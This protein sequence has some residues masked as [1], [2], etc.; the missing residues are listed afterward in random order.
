MDGLLKDIRYALRTLLKRPGF[1]LV[2]VITLGL[3]I[4]AN[5]A[6]FTL[7]NAVIYKKLPVAN[8]NELVLF[9]DSAGEGTRNSDGDPSP[10]RADLFSYS[11]YE[12]FRDHDQS[13]QGLSAFRSGESRLSVR[14]PE[15]QS[16]ESAQRASG[17]LVSGN[18]FSVLGVNALLGR[19]LTPED[20]KA[21][22]HPAAVMSYNHWKQEWNGDPQIVN[23]E[24][25]LNG[26]SFTVVGVAPPEF[27]GVRVRR[28]PDFWLPLAFQPQIELRKSY[29]DDKQIYWLNFVGRLKPSV[30]IEQAQAAANLSLQQ[31]VTAEV[32]SKLNDDIRKAIAGMFVKLGSGARGIS[33]LRLFYSESLKMLMVIVALVLLIAC[34]NVGNL[35]LSR[36]ASRQGEISL[37]LAL[38][39]NRIRIIRQLLTESLLLA[40]LGGIVGIFLAQWGVSL[41]VTLV[42]KTS[43]IDVRPDFVVL[44]FTAGVALVSGLIFGMVPALR[45]SKMDLTSALKEK[46]EGTKR[47]GRV[48]L[49]SA[50]VV[51]Q[52]ALSMVLLAGA[53]LFA[54][55]LMKLQREEVGFNR[56][57]LLLAQVDPRLAGYKPAELGTLYRNLADR[58]NSVPGVQRATL[59][60]Y[61]PMSGT[62]TSSN[63][64][65]VG[66]EAKDNEDLVV[67]DMLIGPGYGESLGA[68][69]LLGRE[70]DQRDTESGAKVAVVNQ[71]FADYFFHGQNPIG[72]QFHFGDED[73]DAKE[74][75]ELI[76]I[77]GVLGNVKYDSAREKAERMVL[78]PIAQAVG[79]TTFNANWQIRTNGDPASLAPA[80]RQAISQVDARLP[81]YSVGTMEEQVQ[82][83]LRQE[84]LIA[85]LVSFFGLLALLLASIGLYGLMAHGVVRRTREIGI[86]MALGAERSMIIWMVLRE[87]MVLV[88]L[89]IAI[90]VP[91]AIGASRLIASQLFG[92]NPS[93]PVTLALSGVLLTG[94]ALLAGF[95]PARKASKVDPL[96][97]LRYE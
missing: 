4:G 53:G 3:G 97:A 23:R 94:V 70:I 16:G 20:D 26:T 77:V 74:K 62:S 63:V 96:I 22:A 72:R 36:A 10:G 18:Y 79:P 88:L 45:A 9:S 33:G 58:L 82:G 66:Y 93:D 55:S 32:G 5:T 75:P 42:A 48:G 49:A 68:Q 15:L 40:L 50:L 24:V 69:L 19:V 90:G 78:R 73:E 43:P 91:A 89:G 41:L 27:F 35:L 52:V 6:I 51:S 86:R 57:N 95:L 76:E 2:A 39:A 13:Y 21:A 60:S 31:F 12:Y 84:K 67:Q 61:T 56:D 34:A 87:T 44:G 81:V 30:T 7:V 8:A 46:A 92:T 64:T 14:R 80:I 83:T 47:R 25:I 28:S 54:R 65:V 29:L 38:G 37:R 59:V 1:T 17:H 85:Q 71:A 11:S